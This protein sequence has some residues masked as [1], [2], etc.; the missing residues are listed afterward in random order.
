MSKRNIHVVPFG[1]QWA[2]RY[3]GSN[4]VLS[5][6]RTQGNAEENAKVRA[7]VD[8]VE[9]VTHRPNGQIRDKDSFGNDPSRIKDTK[10]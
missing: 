9:V 1:N 5:T 6:H 8:K 10:H 2:T 7:R 3:E 4:R